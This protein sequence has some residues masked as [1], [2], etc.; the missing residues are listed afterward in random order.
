MSELLSKLAKEVQSNKRFENELKAQIIGGLLL[1]TKNSKG[2]ACLVTAGALLTVSDSIVKLLSP[3]YALHEIM[4]FRALFAM[5]IVIV[6]VQLEGG[7]VILKTRRPILHFI[8]GSMLVLAN[9]FFFLGLASLPIAETVALFYSAPLFI[10]L[11]SQLVLG[12]KVSLY[13]WGAI[14]LGLVGVVV[15]LR[16]GT[17]IF[18]MTA[19]LPI[20][21][22]FAYACMVMITSKL[23]MQDKA[24]TLTFYI[25]FA[26]IV[27]SSI[28]GL[29]VGDGRFYTPDNPTLGFLFRSWSIPTITDLGLIAACG[30]FVGIGG[31][32]LSQAYRIGQ[33]SLM[34][35]F[36]YS[37]MPLALLLGYL[38][39]G[40]WPDHYSMTGS[41]L[42][43]S[44]GILIVV[45][46]NKV[47]KKAAI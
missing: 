20:F 2:I 46:E 45:I 21:A 38:V 39:W 6:I 43:I 7:F 47:R 10:C 31:Y 29:S 1:M 44:S 32:L 3:S 13:R 26:F 41:I 24:G 23:G 30:F 11:L 35:P 18:K 17:E 19:L 25:Q 22:A 16:P 27:I 12:Q 42:I 4:L 37:S 36:E 5:I 33:A 14:F 34:A 9:M 28:I 15:M 40:D 8:R